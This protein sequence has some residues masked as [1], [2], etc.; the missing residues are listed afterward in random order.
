[1]PT[2]LE[3]PQTVLHRCHSRPFPFRRRLVILVFIIVLVLVLV[4][5]S[6]IASIVAVAIFEFHPLHLYRKVI[7][8]VFPGVASPCETPI[9]A[10][11]FIHFGLVIE[12]ILRLLTQMCFGRSIGRRYRSVQSNQCKATLFVFVVFIV[13][14][15]D[16]LLLSV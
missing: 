9:R 7:T 10:V 4:L 13:A 6:I 2:A 11:L 15:M 14:A 16:D 8:L 12:S 5:I 3:V 1:M